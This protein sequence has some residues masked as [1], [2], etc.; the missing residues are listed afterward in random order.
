MGVSVP[1]WQLPLV[2]SLPPADIRCIWVRSL[3][4]AAMEQTD[5]RREKWAG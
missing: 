2:E 4:S 5:S 1:F 3:E